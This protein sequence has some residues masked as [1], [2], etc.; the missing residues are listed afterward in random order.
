MRCGV[1]L[2]EEYQVANQLER[3]ACI[4]RLRV[5]PIAFRQGGL[6]LLRRERFRVVCHH[7]LQKTH[8]SHRYQAIIPSFNASKERNRH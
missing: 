5:K 2:N 7:F 8:I 3:F 4:L 6:S 1:D